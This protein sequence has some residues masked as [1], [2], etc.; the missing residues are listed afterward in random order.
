MHDMT[1][2]LA[3]PC[4]AAESQTLAEDLRHLAMEAR[5]LAEAELVFQKTRAAYAG[6]EAKGIALLGLVAAV[7]VFFALMALVVGAVI[8]LGPLLSPW[9]AMAAVSL[10]LLL[11]AGLCALLAKTRLA[12]MLNAISDRKG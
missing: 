2:E 4:V 7:L 3:P 5:A 10:A 11:V 6:A 1:P 12:R 8:A 9:G